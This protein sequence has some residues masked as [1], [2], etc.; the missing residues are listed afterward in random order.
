M[1]VTAPK[2]GAATNAAWNAFSTLA[3]I[4]I[5]F[6][7]APLLIYKLGVA[8]YGI[9][10]LIWSLTGILSLVGFGFARFNF[11]GRPFL[12]ILMLSTMMLPYQVTMIPVFVMF[13]CV[14][15]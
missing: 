7:I 14:K 15:P 4:V 11:R 10:L 2:P 5:S 6:V 13:R 1:F 12:F 9:L 3:N 8:Q